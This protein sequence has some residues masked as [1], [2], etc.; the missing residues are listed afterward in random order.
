MNKQMEERMQAEA[1]IVLLEKAEL[2][3]TCTNGQCTNEWC[4]HEMVR[5]YES[6]FRAR[7]AI[8]DVPTESDEGAA[9]DLADS[10][11]GVYPEGENWATAQ[12]SFLAGLAHERAKKDELL[13][14]AIENCKRCWEG[15]YAYESVCE[16]ADYIREL[17]KADRRGG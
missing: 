13:E 11:F 3:G 6:G 14:M 7:D 2:W 1:E 9:K 5:A 10:M 4:W 12:G 8:A 15:E 16:A 17:I